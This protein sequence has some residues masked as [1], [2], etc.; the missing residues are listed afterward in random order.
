MVF[1]TGMATVVLFGASAGKPEAGPIQDVLVGTGKETPEHVVLPKVYVETTATMVQRPIEPTVG[2]IVLMEV[3]AYCPCVRCCGPRAARITA[4]GLKVDYNGGE[5]VAADTS[6]YPFGTRLI[7]PG[8][9][10]ADGAV[11]EVIDRGGKIKGNKLDVFYPDHQ[12]ALEWGR[13]ILPV[14]ILPPVMR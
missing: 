13:Q 8:Y 14:R 3:T 6:L 12:T 2:E 7:V 1:L 11:V 9:G 4:S 10:A 5:F